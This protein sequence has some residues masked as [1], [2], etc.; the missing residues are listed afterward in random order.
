MAVIDGEFFD[1]G[2]TY[3]ANRIG[4]AE[5]AVAGN[6]GAFNIAGTGISAFNG[7]RFENNAA[8]AQG[9]AVWTSAT[10]TTFFTD[11]VFTENSVLGVVTQNAGGGAI[12]NNGGDLIVNSGVFENNR[13]GDLFPGEGA[14]FGADVASGGAIFSVD[15]RVLVQGDSEFTGNLSERAGGAVEI[16]DGEFFDT[17]SL[18]AANET[19]ITLQA[20]PGNGGAI[21]ITGTATSAFNGTEFRSNLAASEGGAVWNSATSSMFFEDVEFSGNLPAEM[22]QTTAEAQ[23]S[24]TAETCSLSHPYLYL[25][26]QTEPPVAGEPFSPLTGEY[27]FQAVLSSPSTDR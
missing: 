18:Y 10:S 4:A 24:T 27:S 12:F 9:G 20:N 14:G 19:G 23:S 25:T 11:V 1:T 15:G 22:T 13:A 26:M 17:G 6:G 5:P 7:T 2:S 3:T 8:S 21:H 16:I